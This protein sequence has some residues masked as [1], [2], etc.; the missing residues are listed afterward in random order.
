MHDWPHQCHK[1]EAVL[2]IQ[3]TVYEACE[4]CGQM[5]CRSCFAQHGCSP[6]EPRS[7]TEAQQQQQ[8]EQS[9]NSFRG[10]VV[11]GGSAGRLLPKLSGA[12]GLG[13]GRKVLRLVHLCQGVPDKPYIIVSFSPLILPHAGPSSFSSPPPLLPVVTFRAS[14]LSFVEA[15]HNVREFCI[16]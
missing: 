1:R 16:M 2:C 6:V 4:H 9:F 13:F 15:L 10:W 14:A 3:C 7:S 5:H 12:W 11:W 8:H